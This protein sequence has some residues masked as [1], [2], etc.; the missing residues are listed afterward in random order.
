MEEKSKEQPS[1]DI[2][3]AFYKSA[4][5]PANKKAIALSYQ[6]SD[7]APKIVATGQGIIADKIIETAKE[8]HVPIHK[9]AKLTESLSA[10]EIGEF[11]PPELYE[12]VAS[13]L[14]YVDDMDRIKSRIS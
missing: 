13:I 8:A 3:A 11:I 4:A 5:T 7:P 10:F 9:D 1:N 12:V 2:L 6:P 14:V